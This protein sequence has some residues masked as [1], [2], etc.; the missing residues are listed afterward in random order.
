MLTRDEAT[1]PITGKAFDVLLAL[2]ERRGRTVEK[3]ELLTLVWAD[4]TVQEANL[5]Q[6]IFTIRRILGEDPDYQRCIATIPRRGY[7]FVA[8][9]RD[10]SEPAMDPP[11]MAGLAPVPR[12]ALPMRLALHLP[13]GAGPTLS[14]SGAVVVDRA[15]RFLVYVTAAGGTSRLFVRAFDRLDPQPLPGTDGAVNPFLSPD[16]EWIGYLAQGRLQKVRVS[17]GVPS[18]ICEADGDLRGAAWTSRCEIV[19]APGPASGLSRV[20]AAGGTPRVLTVLAFDEGERTHRWPHALPDGAHAI[21]TIGHAGAASFDEATLAV[22]SLSG[23]GTPR[24]IL[25]HGTDARYAPP[26]HLLYAREA[27]VMAAPF[28]PDAL[29]VR[30]AAHPVVSPHAVQ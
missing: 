23:D 4:A 3:D 9:V 14:P 16:G 29:A 20:A 21:F 25:R 7:Q 1:V 8:E 11:A 24:P 26:G 28:D 5:S 12:P 15:G 6:Q 18:V 17:A 30:G 27:A 22:V 2:V 10:W 13:P 19:F